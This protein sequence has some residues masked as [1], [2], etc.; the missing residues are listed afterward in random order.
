MMIRFTCPKCHTAHEVAPPSTGNMVACP[1][2][3]QTLAVKVPAQPAAPAPKPAAP[4]SAPTAPRPAA[5][6]PQ[7][8]RPRVE[9]VPITASI[10]DRP[11]KKKKRRDDD[12]EEEG[13]NKNLLIIG[14]VAGGIVAVGGLVILIILLARGG[15]KPSDSQPVARRT[16]PEFERQPNVVSLPKNLEPI[17][18]V[19]PGLNPPGNVNP[20]PGKP[21]SPETASEAPPPDAK[22]ELPPD[23]PTFASGGGGATAEEVHQYVLKSITWVVC[24]NP[25]SR[26]VSTGSGSLVDKANRLVLTN[27]HVIDGGSVHL[28]LFPVWKDGK[29]VTDRETYMNYVQSKSSH[30]I[31]GKVVAQDPSKDLALV[32]LDRLPSGFE[33]LPMSKNTVGAGQGVHSVGSPGASP[34]LWAY[35]PGTVRGVTT[36]YKWRAGPQGELHCDADVVATTS[37]TNPGDSGG[38]LV[39]D[40]GELVGV[41]HGFHPEANSMSLFIE[42]NEA[43]KFVEKHFRSRNQSWVS[44]ARAPLR[45]GKRL[46]GNLT[47]MIKALSHADATIRQK[48][49]NALGEMGPEAKLAIPGLMKLLKDPDDLTRRMATEALN[50]IGP[51]NRGELGA[52]TAALKDSSTEVR[53]YAA[54][55]LGKLGSDAGSALPDLLEAT[56]DKE[57][58]VRANALRA[59]GGMGSGEK[60]KVAPVLTKVMEE[61]GAREIRVAAAEALAGLTSDVPELVKIVKHK[62]ADARV[63]GIRALAKLGKNAKDAIPELTQAAKGGDPAVRREAMLALA[64]MMPE[65]KEAFPVLTDGLKDPDKQMRMST[66]QAMG[67]I[68]A[69]A[70]PAVPALA[71][72]VKDKDKEIR[73]AALT[74]LSRI[75]REA[76]AA[77]PT[78]AETLRDP[79]DEIRDAAIE[80]AGAL[81]PN[82][83]SCVVNLLGLLDRKF[84]PR[85]QEA[86]A[87]RDK[88]AKSLARIGKPAIPA[89]VRAL[90]E[91]N[92]YVVWGA[93]VALGEIGP[94]ANNPQVIRALTVVS[95]VH[96]P[97]I[98]EE[99]D[100]AMRKI[101]AGK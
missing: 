16:T 5:M 13:G 24:I 84:D 92:P 53:A 10:V 25:D 96:H 28:V 72:M 59:L 14:G 29:L 68:G 79:D 49:A 35:T 86:I 63:F 54:L 1:S 74:A 62:D 61:D 51:P 34:A 26:R 78:L 88:I 42:V 76:R 12:H 31:Q 39:N 94:A 71:D 89:L 2:C 19:Q 57:L 90:D 101:R 8:S 99:A 37:P 40:R 64:G 47:D 81:G 41:T 46:A 23:T 67:L 7:A 33:A 91:N 77:A 58:S 15:D 93:C 21:A 3:G 80:A 52:L 100:R 95:R 38:P 55:A 48:A 60:A 87:F 4:K 69:E 82:G 43:R 56:K 20:G 65:A 22:P 98:D 83:G 70:R 11:K 32:Q 50:Q 6:P 85:N 30:A 36:G 66:A 97:P 44:D 18:P 9:D 75:G 45:G 73:L 27:Y 17:V